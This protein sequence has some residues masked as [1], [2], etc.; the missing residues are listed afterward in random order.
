M[1]SFPL[2]LASMFLIVVGSAVMWAFYTAPPP[3]FAL[4]LFVVMGG[5]ILWAISLN[6][7]PPPAHHPE[8]PPVESSPAAGSGH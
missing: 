3:I 7:G 1:A 8:L 6:A 5:V 4:G 2:F